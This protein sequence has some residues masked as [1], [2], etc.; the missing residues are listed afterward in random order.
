LKIV[1]NARTFTYGVLCILIAAS[2]KE[3]KDK[4]NKQG[5]KT[6]KLDIGIGVSGADDYSMYTA[7]E[8]NEFKAKGYIV[9]SGSSMVPSPYPRG[10]P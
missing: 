8:L 7:E 6:E 4:Q 2:Y 3:K 9:V 1:Q 5:K 10:N